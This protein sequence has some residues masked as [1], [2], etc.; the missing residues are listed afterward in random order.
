MSGGNDI[1]WQMNGWLK[2]CF[3][4]LIASAISVLPLVSHAQFDTNTSF[5]LQNELGIEIIPDYPRP[6]EVVYVNLSMYTESLDSS[7]IAWYRDGKLATSG[8]GLTKYSFRMGQAGE[9]VTIEI[10]VRLLSGATFSKSIIL[11]PASVDIIWEANSYVPP[12]YKGR[13]LHPIQ[14]SLKLVA[15]PEF[16]KNGTR[17]SPQN[18]IY[19]WSNGINAYQDQSG[20]GKNVVVVNGSLFGRTE[21]I[22]VLVTDPINNLVAQG[23]VDIDPVDP[24][25]VFYQIDPYYGHIFDKAVFGSFNLK[26]DEVQVLAA[27]YYFSKEKPGLLQYNW[28]LNGTSV[29]DLLGSRTAIFKKP[30]DKTGGSS[31]IVLRMENSNR[32]LQSTESSLMINFK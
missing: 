21:K 3:F 30:E 10:R 8:K 2:K 19:Q 29:D 31:N 4:A 16:F 5:A 6:N 27:P 22:E 11:N 7:D 13:A 15:M 20:Y 28:M 14:G 1:I 23:F 17:I 12:F 9:N 32:I 24:Q 26:S 25:I 18:L